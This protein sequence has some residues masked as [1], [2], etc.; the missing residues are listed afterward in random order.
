MIAPISIVL[1]HI[2]DGQL[3]PWGDHARRSALP[4]VP[5]AEAHG[6]IDFP[7]WYSGSGLVSAAVVDKLSGYPARA[8]GPDLR[9]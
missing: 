6:W 5:V 8:A 4:H 2:R 7:I 9:D 1:P 3:L